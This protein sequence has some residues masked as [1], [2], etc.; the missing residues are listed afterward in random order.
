LIELATGQVRQPF[1]EK[2]IDKTIVLPKVKANPLLK[3]G[4]AEGPT[5]QVGPSIAV[6]PDARLL[7]LA[8]P[9]KVLRVWDILT[10]KELAAFKGHSQ[11]INAIAFAPGGKTLASASADA[12]ALI[13][14][15]AKLER[16]MPPGKALA[17]A[18][19][20][21]CW[22][23]LA[24]PKADDSWA[25]I[26]D[27]VGAP[28]Q[29][30]AIA[31]EALKPVRPADAKLVEQWIRELD[32]TQF[33]ARD[34]AMKELTKASELVL[35][36]IDKALAANPSLEARNRLDALRREIVITPLTGERLRSYRAVE[37]LERIGTP[38]AKQVLE[39]MAGGAPG[40]VITIS[41]QGALR[42]LGSAQQ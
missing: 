16:P 14:D 38:Q 28:E 20:E 23:A 25:A 39:A 30:V 13:W 24:S 33:K 9:D 41:A 27:L 36:A 12:T 5:Y 21:Q 2:R 42:R 26:R 8:G 7:A 34:N 40:S 19:L 18:A 37:V 32:D 31:K 4:Q 3:K 29:T 17:Q 1:G 6:S 35:P 11:A 15:V 22:E 10:G